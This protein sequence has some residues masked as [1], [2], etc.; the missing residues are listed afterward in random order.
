MGLYALRKKNIGNILESIMELVEKN[1]TT[2]GY[3]LGWF[4]MDS[5][6]KS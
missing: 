1:I 6:L 4:M 5:F 2:F 3:I